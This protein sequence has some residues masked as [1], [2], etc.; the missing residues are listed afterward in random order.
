M[1]AKAN[2]TYL[3]IGHVS[4]LKITDIIGTVSIPVI[5]IQ[6]RI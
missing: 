2:E 3:I 5:R 1:A 6:C 4:W